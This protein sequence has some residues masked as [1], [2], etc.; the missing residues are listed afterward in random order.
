MN[1]C[2]SILAPNTKHDAVLKLGAP[3]WLD[4][5]GR[6]KTRC[7]TPRKPRCSRHAPP[8]RPPGGMSPTV[9]S[10][11][12]RSLMPR[13]S[14][15]HPFA[16]WNVAAL[17]TLVRKVAQMSSEDEEVNRIRHC[18]ARPSAFSAHPPPLTVAHHTRR[19]RAAVPAVAPSVSLWNTTPSPL[20][21]QWG[22]F[23][24]ALFAWCLCNQS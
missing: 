10:A 9:V 19:L 8:I 1:G 22:E 13:T 21:P 3:A 20:G 6:V 14:L 5:G 23:G 24:G 2:S 4:H 18:H 17:H 15:S 7:L 12:L 16:L 11:V